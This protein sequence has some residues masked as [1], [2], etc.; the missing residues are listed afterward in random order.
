MAHDHHNAS[1]PS[2]LRTLRDWLIAALLGAAVG[3]GLAQA[4]PA[5]PRQEADGG[6]SR[7]YVT[8]ADG[9]R[10]PAAEALAGKAG[11]TGDKAHASPAAPDIPLPLVAPFALLLGAIAIMP[12]AAPR[13]WHRRYP[14]FA[15]ALGGLVAAYYLGAFGSYGRYSMGHVAI[16][17]YQFA[18]L[19]IGLYFI[20]GAVV[21]DVRRRGTPMVNAAL[22]ATG[23][24]LANLVGTTGASMLLLRP[25][26][27][28]NRGRLRPVHVVFFIFIV[29]NC[30]GALTPIGD[31]PL[32]LGFIKGVPFFWT[33]ENLL[34]EWFFVNAALLAIFFI[35]DS[36]V[37][38]G[39]AEA[40]ERAA[41]FPV[42]VRGGVGLAGVAVVIAAVF[43]DPWL[44]NALG[45]T[46][47]PIGPAVQIAAAIGVRLL[48]PREI[49]KSNGFT[50]EPAKEV[51]VLFIGI[52]AT[53]A[54]ALAFLAQHG[55]R[56]GLA[57]TGHYYF[58]TGSLSAV[59]DNAPTYLA[60]LQLAFAGV[61][62]DLT[63]EAL[64]VFPALVYTVVS[65]GGEATLSG[66]AVLSA[67]SLGAVFF[68]AM[69]YIGNGP[70]F[71]VKSIAENS[72][73]RMPSFLGYLGFSVPIL[74][75][76]LIGAWWVFLR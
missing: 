2:L 66:T 6:G 72:G 24:V 43:L 18:A 58:F 14:E 65:P 8:A 12:L 37:G 13:L 41:G 69:S 73:V 46:G 31:P 38:A 16:E 29:S 67:V 75:P 10:M 63:P 1:H 44:R 21:I 70:N 47:T 62:A 68:G 45:Y 60:F 15:L 3:L 39:A 42:S 22:L 49:Y 26:L 32:Y 56:L 11:G 50:I 35:I 52:F 54:P 5:S 34:K 23:A 28:I 9:T 25:F 71:M 36:R 19:V 53:M 20:S 64:R 51:G 74:L 4:F 59:L 61:G 7:A 17:Y 76:V 57:S 48:A 55:G 33:L 30:G 27:R 40:E